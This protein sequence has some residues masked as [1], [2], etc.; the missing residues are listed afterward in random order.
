MLRVHS[1]DY[2][3]RLASK[4]G[5]ARGTPSCTA[6]IQAGKIPPTNHLKR[7]GKTKIKRERVPNR[8]WQT[9]DRGRQE[10][11]RSFPIGES[12][13]PP[14]RKDQITPQKR[15]NPSNRKKRGQERKLKGPSGGA[16]SLDKKGVPS[17]TNVKRRLWGNHG[18]PAT[19]PVTGYL[20]K[21]T[22]DL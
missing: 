22:Q 3:E 11:L 9:P 18:C 17:D 12:L 1:S 19:F 2:S 21:T 20:S 6:T 4:G 7:L 15:I 13:T 5:Q 14:L 10:A 8:A 16:G